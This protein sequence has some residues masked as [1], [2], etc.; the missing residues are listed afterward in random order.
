MPAAEE[1]RQIRDMRVTS[2]ARSL[3]RAPVDSCSSCDNVSIA[4]SRVDAVTS[5]DAQFD[6]VSAAQPPYEESE[7]VWAVR[8]TGVEDE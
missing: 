8:S 2:I 6:D 7:H 1:C 5:Y 4:E 3:G